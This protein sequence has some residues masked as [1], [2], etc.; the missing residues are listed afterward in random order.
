MISKPHVAV[1]DLN[2]YFAG[3]PQPAMC[4]WV[5]RRPTLLLFYVHHAGDEGPGAREK[6]LPK[7]NEPREPESGDQHWT[8]IAAHL[9]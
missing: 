9:D 7:A 8:L 2:P 6:A 3:R 1:V 5:V 4:F